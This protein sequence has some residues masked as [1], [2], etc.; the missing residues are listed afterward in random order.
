VHLVEH[1]TDG[2]TYALK[3]MR[4]KQLIAL[5]QVEH[6]MNE[7]TLLHA[8]DHPFLINMVTSFQDRVEVYMVLELALGGELFSLLRDRVRFEEP[9]ARFYTANVA[10]AFVHLHD[11]CIA[12]RDLKPENLLLDSQGY[13]KIC[14]F[15]FAKKVNG[16]T[17]T[18]CGTPEYLAPEIISNVGHNWAVDWWAVGILIYEMLCGD[19]PFVHD[20]PMQLYQMILRGSFPFPSNV[21]KHAKDLVNKLLVANPAARLGSLK[22]GSRDVTSHPF[23]KLI[24]LTFLHKKTVKAPYVPPLKGEKDTSNFD[25]VTEADGAPQNPAWALPVSDEEQQLF[26]ALPA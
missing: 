1:T 4:K 26:S 15:G 12:Y 16:K 10:S 3:C 19:P 23:F 25:D 20:D 2:K 14:D 13:L 5:K 6:V 18:L 17:Y 7:L 11:K 22:K 21:G 9:M 24:D 8:C